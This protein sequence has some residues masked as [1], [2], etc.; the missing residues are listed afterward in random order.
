MFSKQGSI[1]DFNQSNIKK[2]KFV[3]IKLH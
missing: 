2:Y 3:L 1:I